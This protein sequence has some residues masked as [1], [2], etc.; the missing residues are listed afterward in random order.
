MSTTP[1]PGQIALDAETDQA[2]ALFRDKRAGLTD[3]AGRV[4]LGM[5]DAMAEQIR[6]QF[7]PG[8]GHIVMAVAQVLGCVEE[9]M[10][11]YYG[12]PLPAN[13]LPTIAGLAAEQ[14]SRDET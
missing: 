2:L 6:E 7:G 14:L 12:T 5:A 10:R 4:V 9:V 1:T 11:A 8:N 13:A 3:A